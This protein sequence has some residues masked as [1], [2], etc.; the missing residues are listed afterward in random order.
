MAEFSLFND[1]LY[2][3]L[4]V[5][6]DTFGDFLVPLTSFGPWQS[7]LG[8]PGAPSWPEVAI[9]DRSAVSAVDPATVLP[10]R[11]CSLRN[12]LCST[13]ARSASRAVGRGGALRRL[14][15]GAALRAAMGRLRH[16]MGA[17]PP[18]GPRRHPEGSFCALSCFGH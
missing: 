9:L 14:Q 7:H 8:P 6:F 2:S 16:P 10:A 1:K 13:P 12:V 3:V 15:G 5:F 17:R 18:N 4:W 11:A